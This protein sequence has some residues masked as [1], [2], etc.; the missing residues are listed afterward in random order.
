[1]RPLAS[2]AMWRSFTSVIVAPSPAYRTHSV[3]RVAVK[4]AFGIGGMT[5]LSSTSRTPPSREGVAIWDCSGGFDCVVCAAQKKGSNARIAKKEE[6]IA[7][8]PADR[9][10]SQDGSDCALGDK[11]LAKALLL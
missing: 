6:R 4:G 2:R 9:F 7:T 5:I 11:P 1:M 3:S 10:Y 8:A